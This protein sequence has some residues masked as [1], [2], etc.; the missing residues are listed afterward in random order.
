MFDNDKW[1]TMTCEI[2]KYNGKYCVIRVDGRLTGTVPREDAIKVVEEL[3]A[4]LLG[5]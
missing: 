1:P 3:N 4:V 5:E 2:F